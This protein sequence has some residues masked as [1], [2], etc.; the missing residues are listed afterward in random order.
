MSYHR[1]VIVRRHSLVHL[2]ASYVFISVISAGTVFAL[3]GMF[4]W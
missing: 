1:E 2:A 4:G 3:A